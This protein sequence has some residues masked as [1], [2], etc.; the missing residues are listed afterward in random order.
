MKAYNLMKILIKTKR[1]S[2]E[3][4]RRYAEVYFKTGKL[5]RK[6][7]GEI[8]DLIDEMEQE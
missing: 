3:E 2:K 5:T 6:E 8:S 1:K 4:L 7:Y